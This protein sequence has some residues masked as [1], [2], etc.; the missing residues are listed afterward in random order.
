MKIAMQMSKYA[1]RKT[2]MQEISYDQK[3]RARTA[4]AVKLTARETAFL[5]SLIVSV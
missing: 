2:V 4:A 1:I 5:S 3:D